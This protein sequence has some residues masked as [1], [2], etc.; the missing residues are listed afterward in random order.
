[1]FHVFQALSI[2]CFSSVRIIPG[3]DRNAPE[4]TGTHRNGSQ[5]SEWTSKLICFMQLNYYFT[6]I[7]L[8]FSVSIDIA[9][10]EVNMSTV[11]DLLHG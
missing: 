1:M 6:I 9:P 4:W 10:F 5:L 11:S 7:Y 8:E 2:F 3:M